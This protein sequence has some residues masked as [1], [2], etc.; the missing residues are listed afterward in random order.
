MFF[1]HLCLLAKRNN[2]CNFLFLNKANP[3]LLLRKGGMGLVGFEPSPHARRI[4]QPYHL[5][6]TP[7]ANGIPY[8]G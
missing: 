1:I 4:G 5:A 2:E 8:R 7:F 3:I 6:A